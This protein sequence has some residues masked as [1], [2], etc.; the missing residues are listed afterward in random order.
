M[1]EL[2][3]DEQ[4]AV[5]LVYLFET[6]TVYQGTNLRETQWE[7]PPSL[8]GQVDGPD[9][10]YEWFVVVERLNDDGSG[11]AISPESEHRNFTWK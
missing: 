4:Y 9:N 11:T 10:L 5:R 6:Q 1:G 7:V 3:P 8:F 2:A